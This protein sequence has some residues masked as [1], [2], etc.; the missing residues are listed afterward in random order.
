LIDVHVYARCLVRRT[1]VDKHLYQRDQSC[2]AGCACVRACVRAEC[3]GR[4]VCVCVLFF[5]QRTT[6]RFTGRQMGLGQFVSSSFTLHNMIYIIMSKP[7]QNLY[8]EL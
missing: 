3:V 2:H 4:G 6:M 8:F 1:G 7:K 5:L